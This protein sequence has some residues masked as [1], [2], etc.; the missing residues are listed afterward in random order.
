MCRAPFRACGRLLAVVA[1]LLAFLPL[2]LSAR[3]EDRVLNIY[4][5]TDYIDPAAVARFERETGIHV[6]YDVYD[7]LETLEGKLLAGRSGYDIVVP[8][9]QPTFARLIAAGA[10]RRI[11]WSRVKERAGLDPALMREVESADPGNHYGAIYLWGTI[12]LGIVADRILALTPDAPLDSWDLLFKPENARRIAPCGITM[13][14]SAT[15]VIPSVLHYLGRDPNSADP[16]DLAAVERTLMA[17][18]P[19]IRSFASGGA[20][21]A[22]AAGETCLVLSYSGDVIQAAAR[23]AEAG[24]GTTVRYV[25]PREGAQLWF[26]MLAIPADAPHPEAAL[27][28]MDF[29]LRPD[30]IAGVTN[31]VRYPNAVPASRALVRPDLLR[32]PNIYPPPERMASF[33]TVGAASP[34][35]ERARNRMWARF[36]AGP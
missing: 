4:N 15:D 2:S 14:D 1:L 22:L 29:V 8:T 27:A 5:W 30:V 35:A 7:S 16:A 21:N 28:F 26:D 9:S 3:A 24:G 33:F 32:D 13:M 25:A 17:I 20:V 12:G 11:D 31:Q 34:T 10:L 19:H 18:R 6:N 23:A 36:K